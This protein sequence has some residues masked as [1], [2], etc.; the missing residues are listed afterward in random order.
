MKAISLVYITTPGHEIA[1]QLAHAAV[2]SGLAACANILPGMTSVYQWE[3]KLNEEQEVVLL[4]K[5]T[6]ESVDDL[7]SFIK[8]RH[9]HQTP[10]VMAWQVTSGNHSF[11]EWI[12]SSVK[13]RRG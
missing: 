7:T 5:T 4:L 1:A 6:E 12:E 13:D 3:G 10:A 11:F 9:P 2:K 8:I